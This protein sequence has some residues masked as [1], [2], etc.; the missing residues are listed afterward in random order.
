MSREAPS[1]IRCIETRVRMEG[2]DYVMQGREA[3]STIRCIETPCCTYPAEKLGSGSTQHHQ[4]HWD[5]GFF[6]LL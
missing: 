4:V 3:P 2:K 1:T 5:V 6:S